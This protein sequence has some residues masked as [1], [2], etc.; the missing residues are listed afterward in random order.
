MSDGSLPQ[1]R[2]AQS[3][4]FNVIGLDCTGA[5]TVKNGEL[6]KIKV[7]SSL[8]TCAAIGEIHLGSVEDYLEELFTCVFRSPATIATMREQLFLHRAL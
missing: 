8:F 2:V 7:Y 4:L 3:R 5:I 1:F 6:N